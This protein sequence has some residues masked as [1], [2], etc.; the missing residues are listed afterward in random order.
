[1]PHHLFIGGKRCNPS[2]AGAS[3]L[4]SFQLPRLDQGCLNSLF[5]IG[6][7]MF[8]EQVFFKW[9][10][11]CCTTW[12]MSTFVSW[13]NRQG[14]RKFKRSLLEEEKDPWNKYFSSQKFKQ[15]SSFH[16]LHCISCQYLVYFMSYCLQWLNPTCM[17]Q[18]AEH[19]KEPSTDVNW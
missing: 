14:A 8:T 10:H 1:M 4:G 9:S 3:K 7:S 16:A 19:L 12:L 2:K 18:I 17:L 5:V 13:K 15:F 11:V 6:S